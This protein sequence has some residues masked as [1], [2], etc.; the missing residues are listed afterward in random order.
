MRILTLVCCVLL[1]GPNTSNAQESE[2]PKRSGPYLGQRPPGLTPELFAPGFISTGLTEAVCNFTPDGQ[3]VYFNVAY[4]EGKDAHGYIAY[5]KMVDGVWIVPEFINFA[6]TKYL[7]AYPFL[8]YDGSSLYFVSNQ[9][10]ND[11][12]IA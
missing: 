3:E 6:N 4:S 12:G 9:P 11:L 2:F 10:T 7:Y 1:F 5:S 8:T